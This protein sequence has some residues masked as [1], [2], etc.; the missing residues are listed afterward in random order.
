MKFPDRQ[1]AKRALFDH[2]KAALTIPC[3]KKILEKDASLGVR[4]GVLRYK[5]LNKLKK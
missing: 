1:E 4:F 2:G 3:K 5:L